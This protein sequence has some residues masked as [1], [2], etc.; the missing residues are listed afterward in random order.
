MDAHTIFTERC[1]RIAKGTARPD[2][3]ARIVAA[4]D[5]DDIP[6]VRV[7]ALASDLV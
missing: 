3:M 2:F 6:D 1:R 5:E 7:A 4:K